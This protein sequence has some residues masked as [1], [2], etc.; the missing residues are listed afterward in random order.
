M[1]PYHTGYRFWIFQPIGICTSFEN[2]YLWNEDPKGRLLPLRCRVFYASDW[3]IDCFSTP[4]S[5]DK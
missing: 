3:L 5:N 4:C 2:M 1:N